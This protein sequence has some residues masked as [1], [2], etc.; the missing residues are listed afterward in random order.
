MIPSYVLL[1]FQDKD[2]VYNLV[3]MID[4]SNGY[5]YGSF[6]PGTS[7]MIISRPPSIL[8][9]FRQRFHHEHHGDHDKL[10]V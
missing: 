9:T 3:K 10:A 6:I 7:Y 4:K 2:S 8:M 5:V 1:A